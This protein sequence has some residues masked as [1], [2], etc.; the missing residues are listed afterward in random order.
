MESKGYGKLLYKLKEFLSAVQIYGDTLS[1]FGAE[2]PRKSHTTD[3]SCST[4]L[5][6][7]T[8]DFCFEVY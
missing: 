7:F 5:F 1:T 6:Q 2:S 8:F 4:K 3:D